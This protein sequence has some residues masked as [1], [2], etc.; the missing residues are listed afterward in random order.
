MQSVLLELA[1]KSTW[2][3]F[4]QGA[5]RPVKE[6]SADPPVMK[7]APHHGQVACSRES[8]GKGEGGG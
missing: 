5:L 4:S 3:V 2:I 8:E 6:Q 1:G 7:N